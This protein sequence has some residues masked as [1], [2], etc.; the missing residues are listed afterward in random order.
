ME[1]WGDY[2]AAISSGLSRLAIA[3]KAGQPL[4]AAE[5]FRRWVELTHDVH[6][7]GR[8]GTGI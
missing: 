7:R 4:S 3:D 1:T 5:G 6:S 8:H 2:V